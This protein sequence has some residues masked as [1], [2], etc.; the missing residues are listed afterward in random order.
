MSG[1]LRAIKGSSVLPQGGSLRFRRRRHPAEGPVEG[2]Q[3]LALGVW[4]FSEQLPV[5]SWGVSRLGSLV[6]PVQVLQGAVL[7]RPPIQLWLTPHPCP[8]LTL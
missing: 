1:L 5:Q 8:P 3:L 7:A 4:C 6:P 2:P